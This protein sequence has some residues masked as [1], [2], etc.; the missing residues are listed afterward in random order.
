MT[1][2]FNDFW[3]QTQSQGFVCQL[4]TSNDMLSGYVIND[5]IDDCVGQ[6]VAWKYFKILEIE[7]Q[8]FLPQAI[9]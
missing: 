8:I 5:L 9:S 3:K 4:I 2:T 1:Y 7:T 6:G